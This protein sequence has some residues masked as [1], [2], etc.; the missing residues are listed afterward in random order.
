MCIPV[1]LSSS[2]TLVR[3]LYI[4]SGIDLD[5]SVSLHNQGILEQEHVC[6][7]YRGEEAA[8]PTRTHSK[9]RI[10]THREEVS[11]GL[12]VVRTAHL[13]LLTLCR[14]TGGTP[15][16]HVSSVCLIR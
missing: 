11:Y 2:L 4:L 1:S 5:M 12:A 13:L 3:F 6:L 15:L 10:S 9:N 8:S 16:F 14:L 7:V